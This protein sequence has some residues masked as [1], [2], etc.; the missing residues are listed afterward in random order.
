MGFSVF[1]FSAFFLFYGLTANQ[2]KRNNVLAF[3]MEWNGL[4]RG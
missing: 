2:C 1:P 4:F 3:L